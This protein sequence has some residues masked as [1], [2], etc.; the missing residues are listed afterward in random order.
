METAH[1]CFV[2]PQSTLKRQVY[3]EER[4]LQTPQLAADS[5]QTSNLY[6]EEFNTIENISPNM[7]PNWT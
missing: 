2:Q 6:S 3:D 1:S 5:D 4:P 7:S